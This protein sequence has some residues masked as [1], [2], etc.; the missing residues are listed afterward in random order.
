MTTSFEISAFPPDEAPRASRFCSA[1]GRPF[2][3]GDKMRSVLFEE[4]G[5]IKRVDLCEEAWRNYERPASAVAW[6]TSRVAEP[7]EKKKIL[8]PNDALVALFE[9]LV[10]KQDQADLR[11]AL[12]LLLVRRR[13][14]R[15]E[16]ENKPKDAL[17]SGRDSIFVYSSRNDACY[18]VP[19]V[20]MNETQIDDVQKRLV[21]LLD[22]PPEDLSESIAEA[23][24]VAER[25][26]EE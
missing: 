15:F 20:P 19:V 9:S 23:A 26:L 13:V 17:K 14:F 8:T 18:A 24:S 11:Y 1:T 4:D 7:E 2:Q 10:F 16:F 21:A 6:W 22:S 25:E 12:A 3:S 5:E